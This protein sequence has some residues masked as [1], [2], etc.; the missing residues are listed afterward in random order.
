MLKQIHSK[1]PSS[2]PVVFTEEHQLSQIRGN[3][4]HPRQEDNANASFLPIP[5]EGTYNPPNG[6]TFAPTRPYIRAKP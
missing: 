6:F 3:T 2:A 1:H 5:L 4:P